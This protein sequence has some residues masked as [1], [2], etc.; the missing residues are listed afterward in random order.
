MGCVCV[1]LVRV[2]GGMKLSEEDGWLIK[3][4]ASV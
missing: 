4:S 3:R 2:S 1:I